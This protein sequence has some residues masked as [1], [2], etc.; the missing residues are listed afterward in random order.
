M[1][2][3]FCTH[4][5]LTSRSALHCRP[6]RYDWRRP[7]HANVWS[8][9]RCRLHRY[10][11]RAVTTNAELATSWDWQWTGA[12]PPQRTVC[13]QPPHVCWTETV[14]SRKEIKWRSEWKH[15]DCAVLNIVCW[16]SQYWGVNR[17]VPVP[18][19][20]YSLSPSVSGANRV[21]NKSQGKIDQD[22]ITFGTGIPILKRQAHVSFNNVD[23]N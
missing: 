15:S 6:N 4:T 8:T 21:K 14:H 3:S 9:H 17:D 12:C 16:Y 13:R 19:L 22:M 23:S 1:F 20:C 2:H 10:Q 11:G 18:D 5:G 7:F